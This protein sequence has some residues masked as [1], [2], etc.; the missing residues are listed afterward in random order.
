M[1]GSLSLNEVKKL[2]GGT[3]DQSFW[4]QIL[5][6]ATVQCA[7]ALLWCLLRNRPR[8]AAIAGTYNAGFYFGSIFVAIALTRFDIPTRIVFLSLNLLLC[9]SL[10]SF[11]VAHNYHL[12][13]LCAALSGIGSA[14]YI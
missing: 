2:N 9:L 13:L 1:Y 7:R 11:Y 8:S 3:L 6:I 5:N 10:L 14:R 4:C 12:Q